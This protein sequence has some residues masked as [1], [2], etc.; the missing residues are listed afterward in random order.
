LAEVE[1]YLTLEAKVLAHMDRAEV[2]E[3]VPVATVLLG[4]ARVTV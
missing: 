2:A 1:V 4:Q 3:E